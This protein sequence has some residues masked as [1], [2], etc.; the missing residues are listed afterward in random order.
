MSKD[1]QKLIPATVLTGYLGAGKTTLL[2]RLLTQNHGY[3]CA[4]IIN[5]F[6]AVSIDHQLVVGTDEEI[7]EL[8]NGCLCCRLRGDLVVCLNDLLQRRKRFDY[9]IIETTG[10]ADPSPIAHTF[11]ASDLA[12]RVRLDAIVT[13][14]D[15]RFFEKE[16]EQ[17]PEPRAQVA[18]ADVI[19]INK[20]DLATPA[21]VDHLERRLQAMNALAKIHRTRQSEIDFAKILNLGARDVT[22]PFEMPP[23]PHHTHQHDHHECGPDCGHDHSHGH[24][25]HNDAVRSFSITEERPLDL[26]KL[27]GWLSVLLLENGEDLYRSKGILRVQGVAKRVIFQSVQ[28]LYEAVPDRLWYVGEPQLSQ[29]VFIGKDLDEAAIRAGFRQCLAG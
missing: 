25:H 2:S 11:M 5:E 7:V 26:K 17:G 23:E 14:V 4:V 10:L 9:I 24:G 1:E 15:A 29:M 20:T 12:D 16:L 13:V 27:E 21:E 6:G 19:L 22:A 3:K 8:K 18:F 28:M